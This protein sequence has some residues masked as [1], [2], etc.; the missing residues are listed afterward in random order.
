MNHEPHTMLGCSSSLPCLN[1]ALPEGVISSLQ[2][3]IEMEALP[4]LKDPA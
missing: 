2:M 3:R 1:T 4:W